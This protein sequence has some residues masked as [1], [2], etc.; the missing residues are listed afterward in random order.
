MVYS[1]GNMELLMDDEYLSTKDAAAELG[2]TVQHT[3]LLIR[4]GKL[5]GR[6]FGRDW[7]VVRESVASYNVSQ[8]EQDSERSAINHECGSRPRGEE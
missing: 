5:A 8:P 7:M 4:E 1:L 2:Y 6:K 3:R